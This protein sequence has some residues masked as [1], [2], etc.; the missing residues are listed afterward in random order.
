MKRTRFGLAAAS[1]GIFVFAATWASITGLSAPAWAQGEAKSK[2]TAAPAAAAAAPADAARAA[3]REAV[4]AVMQAFAK[5]FVTRDAQALSS[6]WTEEGEYENDA[7]VMVRGRD[8]LAKAFETF[9]AKTPEVSVQLRTDGV[10]FLSRDTAICEGNVS[11]KKGPVATP[12]KAR[13]TAVVAREDGQWRLAKLSETTVDELSIEDLEWLIG[14]WRSGDGA[15]AEVHTTY[16]WSPTK[17]FIYVDFTVKEKG[18]S[19]AGRQIIGVDPASG[20]FHSWT[21]G[22]DG[23][24]GQAK[25]TRDDDHWVLDSAGTLADGRMLDETNILRRINQDTFTWQS[26]ARSLEGQE[27][28]DLQPV[29]VSRVK[30]PK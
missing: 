8:V 5:T 20:Q 29:K 7:G 21:F 16:S 1:S 26:I 23:G 24:V 18:L 3:D 30:S 11:V 17:K 15:G 9:F 2:P 19:L 22:A 25:W 12:V 4:A 14:E 28:P 27:F 6:H 13:F 10:R